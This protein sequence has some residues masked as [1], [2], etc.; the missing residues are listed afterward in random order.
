MFINSLFLAI[1]SSIDSLG[2]GITYGVKNTRISSQAKI[3]LLLLSFCISLISIWFG[4]ILK[5]LFSDFITSLIGSFILIFIGFF[6][7]FQAAKKSSTSNSNFDYNEEKPYKTFANFFGIT[8]NII[9]NP[10][11]SDLDK[12]NT[13]DSK[14]ALF[15]GLA[16]SLDCFSIGIGGGILGI[17]F[18]W[19]PVFISL[20]Q[21]AFFSIGNFLGKKLSRCASLPSNVWSFVSGLLIIFIGLFKLFF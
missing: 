6:V 15:L 10:I 12:S 3:I 17:S 18:A 11:D 5:S 19:F 16:L 7:C 20:F 4:D 2:I 14:E 13:I 9:K 8:A 21:L 1:S